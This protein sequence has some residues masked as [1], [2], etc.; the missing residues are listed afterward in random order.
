[1]SA[2]NYETALHRQTISVLFV[3]KA[4]GGRR[5][6]EA[7]KALGKGAPKARGGAERVGVWGGV[8]PSPADYGVWGT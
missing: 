4:V 5:L 2:V 8:S 1:M 3:K 7:P 6:I